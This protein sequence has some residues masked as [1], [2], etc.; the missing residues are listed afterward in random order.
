ME[1]VFLH[2]VNMSITAGW[3]VLAV[4]M[5]RLLFRRAPKWIHCLLWVLVAI[6]LICPISIES[7][8]SLIPSAETVPVDSFL[9]ETPSI[10]SGVPVVDDVVN[11]IISNNFAPQPNNSVN[12][13]QVLSILAAYVWVLG[14][15]M[16]VLYMLITTLRLKWR[17]RESVRL[18]DNIW[19]CDRIATPFILGVIRPRIYLPTTLSESDIVS[20]VAHEQAHIQRRDH[21]WKPLGFLLLTVYWFNPLLWLG[22]VLLCRDIEA[23]CDQK[24]IRD[25]DV[26]QRKGYSETL[27][28]CSAPRHLITACPLAFGETGV[29]SRIKAVLSYKK[30]AFWLI[31]VAVIASVVAAVCLLTDPQTTVSD[32]LDA[33]LTHVI[34]EENAGDHAGD[35]Y[36]TEAHTV[37]GVKLKNGKTVVYGMVLYEEYCLDENG[38]LQAQSGSHCPTVITVDMEGSGY[39]LVEYWTP[40]DGTYYAPTIR[41]KY[42]MRYW[43]KAFDTDGHYDAHHKKTLAA[44]EEHFGLYDEPYYEPNASMFTVSHVFTSMNWLSQEKQEEL[45]KDLP[46]GPDTQWLPVVPI[47][48]TEELD[49]FIEKYAEDFSFNRAEEDGLTPAHQMQ[50]A[51]TETF[52]AHNVLLA[53]Y[54][55]G[56]SG[57]LD[58]RIVALDYADNGTTLQLL[59]DVYSPYMQDE[60]LGQWFMLCSVPN[61]SLNDATKY[62]AVVRGEVAAN[63]Y[64]AAFDVAVSDPTKGAELWRDRLS[65]DEEMYLYQLLNDAQWLDAATIDILPIMYRWAFE[66]NGTVHYV[67]EDYTMVY[68]GKRY[69]ENTTEEQ[70]FFAEVFQP[71]DDCTYVTPY[72]SADTTADTTQKTTTTQ[73]ADTDETDVAVTKKNSWQSLGHPMPYEEAS[74]VSGGFSLGKYNQKKLRDFLKDLKWDSDAP[75]NETP[76]FDAYFSLDGD[77]RYYVCLDT[78]G[79]SGYLYNGEKYATLPEEQLGGWDFLLAD[80]GSTI[81]GT[82]ALYGYF[83]E[84]NKAERHFVLDV[85]QADDAALIG[86]KIRVNTQYLYGRG[87][88]YI[89]KLLKG[90]YDGTVLGDTVY[91]L[92]MSDTEESELDLDSSAI[93]QSG[94]ISG[95][96]IFVT[97]KAVLLNCYDKEQFDV[98]WVRY[99][100]G[101]N[102]QMYEEYTVVFDGQATET[103]PPQV[104]AQTMSRLY[105]TPLNNDFISE[106]RA[107]EI[108]VEY[109]NVQ[110][111]VPDQES[112]YYTTVYVMERPTADTRRYRM[113]SRRVA[114]QDGEPKNSALFNT[115]YLDAVTGEAINPGGSASDSTTSGTTGSTTSAQTADPNTFVGKVK[116]V[117]DTAMLMECYDKE[118]FTEVW[119]NFKKCPDLNPQVGDEYVVTHDGMVQEI[120]PPQV[121]AEAITP[122][123]STP[124]A[125]ASFTGYP[126]YVPTDAPATTVPT[127]VHGQIPSPKIALYFDGRDHVFEYKGAVQDEETGRWLWEYREPMEVHAPVCMVDAET[128]R[129]AELRQN[130]MLGINNVLTDSEV[131]SFFESRFAESGLP[132]S[133]FKKAEYTIHET[134]MGAPT[135]TVV[136]QLND[137]GDTIK[138]RISKT[139]GTWLSRVQVELAEP[140]VYPDV[141]DDFYI[142]EPVE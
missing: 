103:Y 5:L 83:A 59:V 13:M 124:T 86:K 114:T 92:A 24:V 82:H 127:V 58:P 67:S 91:A 29:K 99:G 73:G 31:I 14:M 104:T 47:A 4:V 45:Y 50:E 7:V 90:T 54:F 77:T 130:V 39:S 61:T 28:A 21:W 51:Y 133:C 10:H 27:L 87:L 101:M 30:P 80:G 52:F 3:L 142:F 40:D 123:S 18:R 79:D 126:V 72:P 96:V 141:L 74:K 81:K 109:W 69:H 55:K 41:E 139:A 100:A 138:W 12:P 32:E 131:R 128:G 17:V 136:I 111:D 106:E 49:A 65:A 84:W 94:T 34:L 15:V 110:L 97:D 71:R 117:T 56:P 135:A 75:S 16:M 98:V 134:G 43:G 140:G 88:P 120:Y 6:R 22:Y 46:V 115:I 44:A 119:V 105:S 125:S 1:N 121:T 25:M 48:T 63:V 78:W 33:Y 89:G 76:L 93:A 11:P 137:T 85:V 38:A 132:W 70:E 129:V 118:K 2:L 113:G 102:P 23:A 42:P 116:Q 107:I 19:Q 37:F 62:T 9:Y 64:A 35:A 26:S 112:G 36:P 95:K 57:S 8:L 66:L 108:A 53:V 68:D 20:V 122:V 60:A